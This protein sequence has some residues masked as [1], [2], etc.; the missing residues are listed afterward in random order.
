MAMS[1]GRKCVHSHTNAAHLSP[2]A[3]KR[4]PGPNTGN[5]D[6]DAAKSLNSATETVDFWHGVLFYRKYNLSDVTVFFL[7]SSFKRCNN[8]AIDSCYCFTLLHAADKDYSLGIPPQI[9]PSPFQPK[10]MIFVFFGTLS[11]VNFIQSLLPLR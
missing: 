2:E 6:S 7:N 1:I 8:F 4:H 5:E 9:W 3:G 10:K 11:P